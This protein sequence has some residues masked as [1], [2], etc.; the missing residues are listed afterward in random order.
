M[1]LRIPI[2][3]LLMAG[4][5]MPA[6]GQS[7]EVNAV[8]DT[9]ITSVLFYPRGAQQAF[10]MV[11]LKAG[12]GALILKFDHLGHD[13]MEY[14]YTIEHCNH[15][16]TRSNMQDFEYIQGFNEDR[17][18]SVQNSQNTLVPYTHHILSL[19]NRNMRWTI[20]GNYVLKIFDNLNNRE[21]VM[22]RRF[23]VVEPL[24]AVQGTFS[25][26]AEVGKLNTHHEI[27]FT[28]RYK[29]MR[30][31]NP[32]NDVHAYVLQNGRW[33]NMIG[34]LKPNFV[35]GDNLV[36][37]YQD[38]VVFPAGKEWRFFDMRTFDFRGENVRNI[39]RGRDFREVTLQSDDSRANGPYI[40]RADINGHFI[41]ENQTPQETFLQSDYAHVL[42][43][44]RQ[45]LPFDE[46]DVYV[47]GGLTNWEINPRYKMVYA[48]EVSMYV[49]EL[50]L[51]QG[52]YNYQYLLINQ[53]TGEVDE[54]GVEGNWFE[55]SNDYQI[56][57]YF[58]PFGERYDRLL[59]YGVMDSR[60]RF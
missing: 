31:P 14:V 33:D 40:L 58:R 55:A 45:N 47:F 60:N 8:L 18:L 32:Q 48:P 23:C 2:L 28:V 1:M 39:R 53:E 19:P 10:P 49:L 59:G 43:S 30:V 29:N 13:L 21:L 9:N 20:S 36:F 12:D 26:T 44:L 50:P 24:W 51:K 25:P 15:D 27:D 22:A 56:L 17:I 6:M 57:A 7:P 41:N 34:P 16:W 52:Y 4:H 38:K 3:L 11:E 46:E 5:L 35:R 42:F 54:R 37:D